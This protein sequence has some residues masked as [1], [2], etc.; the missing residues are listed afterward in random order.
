VF[1]EPSSASLVAARDYT[2]PEASYRA[3][4]ETADRLGLAR[5]VLVQPSIYGTDND[6]LAS[7]LAE[8]PGR[9]RGVAVVDTA[10][11]AREIERLHAAG[12]RGIRI[13][14]VN[15]GPNRLDDLGT[16]GARIADH[17][18]HIE[19]QA[20]LAALD[21]DAARIAALA[22]V[23]VVLDHFSLL[24]GASP[25][26]QIAA[27]ERALDSGTVWVKLS[28][29]YRCTIEKLPFPGMA[30]LA[31]RLVARHDE[32]LLWGSDWPHP[33]LTGDMPC[34]ADLLDL[35][36]DWQASE[37]AIEKIFVRNPDQIYWAD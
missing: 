19:L 23:P 21:T 15:P 1:G 13:N 24:H 32:Q 37:T 31:R 4:R 27:L 28:A 30:A 36:Y 16:L 7:M 9:L 29:P 26:A 18:W 33:G 34:D 14:L 2:P 35:V 17:G 10:V 20:D 22:G 11:T 5:A 25:P 8:N 6:L 12:V 3:Y